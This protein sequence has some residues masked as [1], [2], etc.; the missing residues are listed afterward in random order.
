MS[1]DFSRK[2]AIEVGKSCIG[3]KDEEAEGISDGL[4]ARKREM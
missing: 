2:V 1:I 4:R 3:K